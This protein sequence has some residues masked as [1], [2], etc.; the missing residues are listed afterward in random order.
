VLFS[1]GNYQGVSDVVIGK[2]HG[3]KLDS[4]IA[5]EWQLVAKYSRSRGDEVESVGMLIGTMVIGRQ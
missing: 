5:C 1:G 3:A 4:N 2:R